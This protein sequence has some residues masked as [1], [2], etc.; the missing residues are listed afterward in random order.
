MLRNIYKHLIFCIV[1]VYVVIISV[2]AKEQ[3]LSHAGS[4]ILNV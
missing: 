2:L 1:L 3:D 4:Q